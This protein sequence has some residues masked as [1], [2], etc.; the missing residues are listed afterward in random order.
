MQP[1]FSQ[2]IENK[3]SWHNIRRVKWW[4][5]DKFFPMG[6]YEDN[7]C[8]SPITSFP[9]VFLRFSIMLPSFI[10]I[11]SIVF[12]TIKITLMDV[13]WAICCSV[14][15]FTDFKT[16]VSDKQSF[17]NSANNELVNSQ[18]IKLLALLKKFNL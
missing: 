18:P 3:L 17:T 6:R 1:L 9:H 5:S 7:V 13:K 14:T 4:C 12:I 15:N 2:P 10:N 11:H 16:I 8:D